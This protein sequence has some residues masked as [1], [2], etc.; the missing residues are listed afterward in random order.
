MKGSY[1]I[2]NL[3]FGL[4]WFLFVQHEN[5]YWTYLFEKQSKLKWLKY[6]T[7]IYCYKHEIS[8]T[9]KKILVLEWD[10]QIIKEIIG[11]SL[12]YLLR[13]E[14]EEWMK[15]IIT[16]NWKLNEFIYLKE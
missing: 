15:H 3:W 16:R 12:H 2:K 13:R 5:H 10:C 6:I 8:K 7:N 9:I 11:D 4:N 1:G 14:K